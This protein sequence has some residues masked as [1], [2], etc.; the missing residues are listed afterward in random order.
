MIKTKK[1]MVEKETVEDI[2]CDYCGESCK[3]NIGTG[4]LVVFE[5]GT[6][7]A[8]WGYWSRHD[9]EDYDLYI[10]EKCFFNMIETIKNKNY[11]KEV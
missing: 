9:D 11:N 4:N 1:T 3:K 7:Q 8:S 5:Y 2:L 6:L 10:C